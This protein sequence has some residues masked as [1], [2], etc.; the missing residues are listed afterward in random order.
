MPH[1]AA[2][3]DHTEPLAGAHVLLTG[4]TGFL[5]QALLARILESYPNTRMTL[6]LRAKGSATGADRLDKLLRKPVFSRLRA[7]WGEAGL[8]AE[9][10]ERVAVVEGSLDSGEELALPDDL[11]TAVHAAGTV[12]FDP[13]IDDAFATNVTGV[14]LLYE[15]LRRLPSAPHVV[16]VSTAYVAGSRR[17]TVPER[18][19]DHDVDWR[20]ELAHATAAREEVE[21]ESRHPDLLR[22]AL[23]EGQREHGKSGPQSAAEASERWRRDWVGEQ[24]VER[25]RLRAR[26]L[27]WPD[28]YTFTKALGERVAEE[29]LTGAL[30]L[31]VLRPAI[32]E[33]AL[34]Y[35][36]PG[37]IDG[38]KMADPLIVAFGRGTLREFP[39]LP[40]GVLDLIPVDLVVNA[41]LAVAANPPGDQPAYYHAGSG[42]RN[43]LTFRETYDN[44]REYFTNHPM[45]DGDRG[46]VKVPSWEFPGARRVERMLRTGDRVLSAAQR[47]LLAAPGGV[48]TRRWQD[49]LTRER[50]TLDFLRYYADI[51]GV[52]TET[53]VIY[54]DARLLA[55]HRSLPPER[56]AEHGFD[57]AVIDWPH[58]LQRVHFPA[59]TETIRRRDGTRRART[60]SALP[61]PTESAVGETLAVFDMEGTLVASNMIETYLLARL[62]D[63]PRS[64][65]LTE[66]ADLARALP[67]Y[68]AA[69][70]RDRGEFLRT[71]LR[72]YAE[73][74]ESG[75]R[76]LVTDRLGDALL[77]RAFPQALR[78]IRKHRAA[79]HRTVLITG[80]VDVL[81]EP[82]APLFDEVVASR[83]HARGGRY[84]G[85]LD[86]P[87]LV[88]EARAAWLRHYA[89]NAGVE[90]GR[91]YAY[92]DSYSDRPLL[93]AVGHPVAVNPDPQLYRHARA[94]HWPVV[95]W[96]RHS[97]S[98]A[99]SFVEAVG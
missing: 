52:Y 55:L 24:L 21:A 36:Y 59:I 4:G 33:S 84:S 40:D 10:A 95:S 68:L 78:R 54:T 5:G 19:L 69:E 87:P 94:N 29:K 67:R 56:V 32:V 99:D 42:S 12:S 26:T 89:E 86:S 35:P 90:L 25:G 76:R 71:F 9:V 39:G 15:A 48:R 65:W 93:E 88:G 72:R 22:R 50:D 60:G 3:P 34:R 38:F 98:A 14:G 45:P 74:D 92:G 20:T 27:G 17:G 83:M 41:I 79:G 62:A 80:A 16:H 53:E 47:A 70:R 49:D 96:S 85:F 6:L 28:V 51:Y 75:L 8:R 97:L 37:W 58:Y 66:L 13:P 57:P 30:P 44:V 11:T 31:S 18:S 64:A 82:L 7:R 1:D 73:V 43:P 81:V 77:R 23:D 91:S 61:E 46:Q 63:L 2:E